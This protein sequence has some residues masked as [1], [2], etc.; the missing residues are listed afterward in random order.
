[1]EGYTKGMK[2]AISVP[3]DIFR[4]GE[5]LAR[6]LGISRSQL[7]SQA[8]EEY[9]WRHTPDEITELVNRLVDELGVDEEEEAFRREITRR[10]MEEFEW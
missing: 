4:R 2:T 6:S 1:M 8:L 10:R 9:V 3:D 7:Y 5:A